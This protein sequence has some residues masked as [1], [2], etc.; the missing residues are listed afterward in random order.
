MV[1]DSIA[2]FGPLL[3]LKITSL[4]TTEQTWTCLVGHQFFGHDHRR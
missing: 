4:A 3:A 2:T 1:G